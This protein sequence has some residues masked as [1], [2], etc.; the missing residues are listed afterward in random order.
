MNP[1]LAIL[2]LMSRLLPHRLVSP[3][4]GGGSARWLHAALFL[5]VRAGAE[6][7]SGVAVASTVV[8]PWP[9]GAAGR[10]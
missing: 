8:C 5:F 6:S 10:G 3:F 4:R 7:W 1:I 2:S 9:Q